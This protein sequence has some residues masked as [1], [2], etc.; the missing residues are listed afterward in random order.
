M[1]IDPA[2]LVELTQI[3]LDKITGIPIDSKEF[4]IYA[5]IVFISTIILGKYINNWIGNN[6]RG[7]ILVG[8]G[9]FLPLIISLF[10]YTVAQ[11]IVPDF[12]VDK[13]Q[14][15]NI[16][17]GFGIGVG[18]ITVVLISPFLF[19]AGVIMSVVIFAC[20]VAI[21]ILAHTFA[22]NTFLSLNSIT[23]NTQD[24]AAKKESMLDYNKQDAK[25]ANPNKNTSEKPASTVY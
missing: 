18:I 20:G 15:K 2:Q 25:T 3:N 7:F 21:I 24:A 1:Q 6:D 19:N 11:M 10:A 13:F 23:Q 17:F 22:T 12:I 5:A 4:G 9:I 8:I 16:S 14:Y